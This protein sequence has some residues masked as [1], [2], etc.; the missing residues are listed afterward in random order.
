MRQNS[1]HYKGIAMKMC[2]RSNTQLYLGLFEKET[3]SALKRLS[4]TID[5]AIDIGAADGEYTLFFL[6]KTSASRIYAFEPEANAGSAL[7]AAGSSTA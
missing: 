2:L 5:T 3:H 1:H 7:Q 4:N 6:T